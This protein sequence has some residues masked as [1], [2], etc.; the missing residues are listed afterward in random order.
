MHNVARGAYGRNAAVAAAA[1]A[2]LAAG[3]NEEVKFADGSV[4]GVVWA[5]GPVAGATVTGFMRNP[6]GTIPPGVITAQATTDEAGRFVLDVDTATDT[7]ILEARGGRTVEAASGEPV[8]LDPDV[9]LRGVVLDFRADS[10]VTGVVVTPVTTLAVALGDARAAAGKEAL[11]EDAMRRALELVGAHFGD[12]DAAAV[13]PV[14]VAG[15]EGEGLDQLTE[16]V[17]YGLVLA[18]WS[19]LAKEI[20]DTSKLTVNAVNTLVLTEAW[21]AD[22]GSA[23]ALF[24]GRSDE[25]ALFVGACDPP[26]ECA[27]SECRTV[28]DLDANTPRA[29]LARALTVFASSGR[30]RTALAADDVRP[31]ATAIAQDDEPELFGEAPPDAFDT[32]GPAIAFAAPEPGTVWD[33][34]VTIDVTASD[35]SGVDGVTVTID[36]MAAPADED[37]AAERYVTTALD[38]RELAEGE[39][40]V[41]AHAVDRL[42]NASEAQ[43]TVT[44]N[45]EGAGT[46]SGVVVKGPVADAEVTAYAYADGVKGRVLGAA[47]TGP[48]GTYTI[49]MA[50]GYSGPV[51]L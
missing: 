38:T 48:D 11:H 20:A 49:E 43:V 19:R 12:V 1:L 28:C 47:T 10:D 32:E 41:V 25:G 34:V 24:D 35:P 15:P 40:D 37:P 6:D 45:N 13:E 8:E 46:V 27:G 14:D 26:P 31:L 21:E 18:A 36:G 50:E 29:E 51:L 30:N 23:E 2:A 42:G 7:V 39:H 44:V 9:T 22:L 4:A 16:P 17:R 5:S 3:C 33:G